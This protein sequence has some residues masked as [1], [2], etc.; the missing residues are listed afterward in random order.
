M[1]CCWRLIAIVSLT[2]LDAAPVVGRCVLPVS[3]LPCFRSLLD[4]RSRVMVIAMFRTSE[5]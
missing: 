3:L 1:L 2:G 4:L 5:S